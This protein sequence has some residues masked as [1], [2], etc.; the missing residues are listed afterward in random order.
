MSLDAVI[1]ILEVH[2]QD[3]PITIDRKG[4]DDPLDCLGDE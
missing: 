2:L 3:H 4:R 1:G